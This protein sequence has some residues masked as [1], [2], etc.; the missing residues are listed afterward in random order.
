MKY[1]E[2]NFDGL[3]GPNHNYGGLAFG[4]L[5][6]SKNSHA[7]SYP[8]AAALQGLEKMRSLVKLGYKQGFFP[9][10]MRPDL[11]VLRQ[12]G[13]TGGDTIIINKVAKQSPELLSM[14]YSASAMWAA[15][16]ATVTPSPDTPDNKVH[17]T[18]ANLLTMFHRSIEHPHTYQILKTVF[19]NERHFAV[20]PALPS[21]VNFSD[22]GAANHTRF[23]RQYGS[24]GL[25]AFVYGVD[26]SKQKETLKFPARQSLVASQS[27]ARA[28]GVCNRSAFWLQNPNAIDAGAFHNDVVA[29]GNGPLL[30]HHEFAFENTRLQ[31]YLDSAREH[32]DIQSVCV[33]NNDVSIG[34][35]IQSYLFNSQLLASPDGD[36]SN[37]RLIAPS[38]CRQTPSVAHYLNQLVEDP[39]QPIREVNFVDVRQS[40]SNGGGPACLRLRVVLSELEMSAVNSVFILNEEKIDSLC[41]WVKKHYRDELKVEDLADPHF[42]EECYSA[43]KDLTQRLNLGNF[44]PFQQ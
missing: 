2:V 11:A 44:Y 42:M 27:I 37:M 17:F 41:H 19:S 23:C 43:L 8:K 39:S 5:A 25:S 36:M 28:H 4:N 31:T 6:S 22:E 26:P 7:V 38:E 32:V 30:L 24:K 10:Q 13:F 15:N 16:A 29:V 20:H 33:A 18:P 12:A 14:V 3:I 1:Y 9:P 35:A 34:D 40:M 21:H